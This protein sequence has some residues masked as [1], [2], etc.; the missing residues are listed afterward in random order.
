LLTILNVE[1]SLCIPEYFSAFLM[2]MLT[3]EFWFMKEPG[4]TSWEFD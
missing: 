3:A 2:A 1:K 4:W